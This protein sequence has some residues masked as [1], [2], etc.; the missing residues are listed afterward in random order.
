MRLAGIEAFASVAHAALHEV[1]R[2]DLAEISPAFED[3]D[4]SYYLEPLDELNDPDLELVARAEALGR[5][6]VRSL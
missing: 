4:G 3:V 2:H 6:S 1:G 5:S